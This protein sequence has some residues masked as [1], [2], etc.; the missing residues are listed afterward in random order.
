MRVIVRQLLQKQ[1]RK[2]TKRVLMQRKK[3]KTK[4]TLRTMDTAIMIPFT[5]NE[6]E[7]ESHESPEKQVEEPDGIES[8]AEEVQPQ[9][10]HDI[11]E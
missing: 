3:Q 10:E 8:T 1:K 6:D 11:I 7:E 2:M 5:S 9:Q 4:M